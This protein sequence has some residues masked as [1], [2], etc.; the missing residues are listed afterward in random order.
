M[1][2]KIIGSALL[3]CATSLMGFSLAADCSKRP[4]VL[5]ELQVLMQMFENEISYLSNL[6]AQS[7]ERIYTSSKTDASLLFKDAAKNLSLPGITADMA[8]EKAVE[9]TAAKLGLSNEDKAILITFGKMLGSSDLE[10]QINNINLVSSQLKLQ[11]MKAEQMRQ[12]NE[13]MYKSLGV[14]SGLAIVVV[15]F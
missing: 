1:I 6:L 8:W 11:E 4:K 12:K 10:G 7:F 9:N 15:L 5:R 14:L 2:I 3:M 13:K